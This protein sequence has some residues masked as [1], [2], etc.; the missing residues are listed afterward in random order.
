MLQRL[1][2]CSLWEPGWT[3]RTLSS[4]YQGS[5]FWSWVA[6]SYLGDAGK[7]WTATV[8][9]LLTLLQAPPA[10]A[11]IT[12][13]EFKGLVP[14]KISLS[15]PLSFSSSFSFGNQNVR[16]RNFKI[17]LIYVDIQRATTYAQRNAH[18]QKSC[19]I[20]SLPLVD[21]Q[22]RNNL[23]QSKYT[24]KLFLKSANPEEERESDIPSNR[25]IKLNYPVRK[26]Q[27]I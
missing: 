14:F 11:E 9:L 21:P 24:I 23:Q 2:S 25:I 1:L 18:T 26:T 20:L 13:R 7:W 19:E 16:S 27:M 5:V 17:N 8:A 10:I 6:A 4:K 15:V 3:I 12:I 22:H